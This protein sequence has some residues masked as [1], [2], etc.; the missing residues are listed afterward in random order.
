[1]KPHRSP[2]IGLV[3][4]SYFPNVDGVFNV[5]H[6]LACSLSDHAEVHVIIP[7]PRD[8]GATRSL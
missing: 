5:V 6:H 3:S 1:M 8:A 4:D 2:V 7:R